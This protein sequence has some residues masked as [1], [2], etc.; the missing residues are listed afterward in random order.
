MQV[1]L[2]NNGL[3]AFKENGFRVATKFKV[4]AAYG[5]V[6]SVD[7]VDLRGTCQFIAPIHGYRDVGMGSFTYQLSYT[8]P[9]LDVSVGEIGIYDAN[10]T[11]LAIGVFDEPVSI[12]TNFSVDFYVSL[13]EEFVAPQDNTV[14]VLYG[15]SNLPKAAGSINNFYVVRAGSTVEP[16]IA[17]TD[18][19]GYWSFSGYEDIAHTVVKSA[20]NAA[21]LCIDPLD[22]LSDPQFIGEYIIQTLAGE[23]RLVTAITANS[24]TNVA[25]ASLDVPFNTA[26]D[27]GTPV[28]FHRT[29]PPVGR[30]KLP[31]SF[32]LKIAGATVLGGIKVGQNL[33]ISEDGTLHA[34]PPT[35]TIINAMQI[36]GLAQVG[37]TGSY[38]DLK[39]LP[40]I[41]DPVEY[42]LPN[43]SAAT[44]GG[45]K[46]GSSL[47]IA[48]DGTLDVK[49]IPVDT[50]RVYTAIQF[51]T[52]FTQSFSPDITVYSVN[53]FF[54]IDLTQSSFYATLE[55]A[56]TLDLDLVIQVGSKSIGRIHFS[57]G[58]KIGDIT[59]NAISVAA[60]S[61]ISVRTA[62]PT[63]AAQQAGWLN[64]YGLAL[65]IKAGKFS[66]GVSQ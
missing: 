50:S 1:T 32:S 23:V 45:V 30:I 55:A 43:A 53:T 62:I 54:D 38:H 31:E 3:K 10:D 16:F 4:G 35:N 46:V 36:D 24:A 29:R 28:V 21:C 58:Q 9:I 51:D 8:A 39:D 13:N 26:V 11:L 33:T 52:F 14:P 42:V 5:Y 22:N 25:T 2:T 19:S 49:A 44:L 65:S 56:P 63:S 59:L 60:G 7:D 20:P 6:P 18:G 41:E 34:V 27:A 40:T 47:S 17:Y 15:V 57:A 64:A 37:I 12:K 61:K 48:E 66:L